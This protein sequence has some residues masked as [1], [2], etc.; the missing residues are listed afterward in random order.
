[1]SMILLPTAYLPNC[2]YFRLL[3]SGEAVLME[4]HE[5]YLKQS[6][7]NR[8]RIYSANGPLD[9]SIP[10]QKLAEKELITGKKIAYEERWQNQHWRA[11]TS[12][13]KNSPYFEYFEDELRPFY[14]QE[15][16]FL[17]DYN[18]QLLRT[19]LKILRQK[20]E[21]G[22]TTAFEKEP[23]NGPDYRALLH[24]KK[25]AIFDHKPYYQVFSDKHGFMPNLSILDLLFHEGLNSLA[26]LQE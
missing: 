26:Y 17:F 23:A 24:P 15:F 7:R 25:S 12:A 4:K 1:M 18:L 8:C 21:I 2:D 13:Y 3:L 20:T 14:E 5:H 9:L 16:E 22:F 10:L 11:L 19:I 6:Y